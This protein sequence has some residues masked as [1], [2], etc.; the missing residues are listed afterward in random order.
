[1]M[2][3]VPNKCPFRNE[4]FM[5][6]VIPGCN[7]IMVTVVFGWR[8]IGKFSK[9]MAYKMPRHKMT[10]LAGVLY[11]AICATGPVASDSVSILPMTKN[12]ATVAA[13]LD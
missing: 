3:I 11:L 8:P 1:M 5:G 10:R 6:R 12:I 4:P 9:I 13:V 7:G 2:A